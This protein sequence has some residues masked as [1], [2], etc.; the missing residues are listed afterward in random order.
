VAHSGAVT[1]SLVFLHKFALGGVHP[2]VDINNAPFVDPG[3][4]SLC[5]KPLL[6]ILIDAKDIA[7]GSRKAFFLIFLD[8]RNYGKR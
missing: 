5:Q 1:S 6:R 2:Y 8:R 4:N 3:K 7:G